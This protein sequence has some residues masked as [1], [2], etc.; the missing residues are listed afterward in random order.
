MAYMECVKVD[1]VVMNLGGVCDLIDVGNVIYKDVLKVQLFVN[2]LIYIDM[3]GV[4]VLDYFNVVVIKL[5][6]F[7][8][9]V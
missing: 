1:F 8:V 6:D 3:I 4:E 7:G 5:V 2:I 9:Y